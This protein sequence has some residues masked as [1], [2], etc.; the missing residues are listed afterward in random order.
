LTKHAPEIFQR[1]LDQIDIS[2]LPQ[3]GTP[4]FEQA[5]I[6]HYAMQYAARGWNAFV[7][8]DDEFVRVVAVP[9]RGIAPKQYVLGLLQ[10]GFLQDALPVLEALA[11]MLDDADIH[12]NLGICLSELGQ[13]E[14]SIAPLKRCIEIDPTYTNA[15]VGLGVSYTKLGKHGEAE[16]ALRTA[17]QQ[18]P[19]NSFAKRNLAAV[20]AR[21]GKLAEALPYFRQAASLAPDDPGAAFGL[22][23][24]LDDLG[25]DYRK[26]A[27]KLYQ[28]IARR[29]PN[30][31]LAE[32]A[33]QARSKVG[34]A[35]LRAAVSGNVRM[36][37]V[38]YMQGAMDAFANLT[39]Q[40]LGEV[41]MEIALLGRSGLAIN[42]PHKRYNLTSLPGDYSGLQL[43]AMMHVGLR[44]L[45]PGADTGTGLDREHE[46][47]LAMRGKK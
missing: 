22:A 18:D 17:L 4:E 45:D 6:S 44:M 3:R 36:D 34:Q 29:F 5:V 28:D 19:G 10:H 26:E 12:Y 46:V 13:I 39:R 47:A 21:T 9:E 43:L 1:P 35:D 7:T 15:Y 24:C 23:Q 30:H 14:R 37:A 2:G 33:L 16:Q 38:F 42:N 8:V 25:G 41:T 27:D 40:Q 32:A 31:P 11:G 20:L